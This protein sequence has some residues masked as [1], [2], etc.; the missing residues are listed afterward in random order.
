MITN[1]GK[2]K[3]KIK[4][5]CPVCDNNYYAYVNY[6]KKGRQTTCS[7]KC[8]YIKRGNDK[9]IDLTGEKINNLEIIKKINS[10]NEN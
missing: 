3:H 8:S 10:S 2:N 6:L 7:I 4:R 9:S 1:C 5:K